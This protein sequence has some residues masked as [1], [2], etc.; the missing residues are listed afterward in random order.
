MNAFQ[1]YFILLFCFVIVLI[2]MSAGNSQLTAKVIGNTSCQ[3]CN[4][5][6]QCND[7]KIHTC[8]N[9]QGC[10]NWSVA[11]DCP[12]GQ[13]C[14]ST[15][16]LCAPI[17]T[18]INNC[19]Q[20]RT[21][22]NN[23]TLETCTENTAGCLNWSMPVRCDADY[24]CPTKSAVCVHGCDSNDDCLYGKKCKLTTKLC[25]KISSITL[26]N[27][28]GQ[29]VAPA[30]S[31]LP[32]TPVILK[33]RVNC[34]FKGAI[35]KQNCSSSKGK[36]TGRISCNVDI[37]GKK[38]TLV[39]WNSSCGVHAETRITGSFKKINFMCAHTCSDS[40]NGLSF[41]IFGKT[42][43]SGYC[44]SDFCISGN[45]IVEKYCKSSKNIG[46][47]I[48]ACKYG[49]KDGACVNNSASKNQ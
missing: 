44:E 28:T 41:D 5:S 48:Y 38:D 13:S 23:G 32:A 47:N 11:T 6:S 37:V 17:N 21:R 29:V 4:A 25:K 18:C 9:I 16:N 36:C 7:A 14:N 39:S 22:C 2:A 30:A 45:K 20:G 34:V 1:S 49:C 24:Y 43:S 10:A 15:I 40:D 35:G 12:A 3:S 27:E 46:S 33:E 8:T 42:C 31:Q 26:E 19:I